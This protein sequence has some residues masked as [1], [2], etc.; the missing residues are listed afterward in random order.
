[1][2]L[3]VRRFIVSNALCAVSLSCWNTKNCLRSDV[4][5]Q[6]LLQQY[7]VTTVGL[8]NL[9]FVIDK[10]EICVLSTT[11]DSPTDAISD[12]LKV[13][14]L[15]RRFLATSFFLT[16]TFAY[17]RSFSGV[18][19]GVITV[20]IFTFRVSRRRREMYCGHQ[21]LCVCPRPHVHTTART[22]V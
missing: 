16:D 2:K 11:C 22:R 18:F 4:W 17:D 13:D 21:R 9:D 3:R 10:R 14:H 1:M 5:R 12:W 7:R 19:F 6:K 15:C 8:I 20:N